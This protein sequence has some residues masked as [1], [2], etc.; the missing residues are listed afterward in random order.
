MKM[1]LDLLYVA[2][3]MLIA[4]NSC[5]S[6]EELTTTYP[7]LSQ[8]RNSEC[9]HSR[10]N[11]DENTYVSPTIFEIRILGRTAE[12]SLKSLQY[13]C[14][15][16]NVNVDVSYN[17]GVMTIIEYPSS[18]MADCICEVD[19]SFKIEELPEESF[20]L[21]IYRGNT[22]GLYDKNYPMLSEIIK[23]VNGVYVFHYKY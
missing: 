16:E 12:C 18:D 1:R 20:Q 14:D 2:A 7:Y 6:T 10:A 5:T 22:E 3:V 4:M 11:D 23:P 19:A 17:D 13:P 21:E 8:L 9:L 15:F